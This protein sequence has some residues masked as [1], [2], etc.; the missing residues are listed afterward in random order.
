MQLTVSRARSKRTDVLNHWEL[1]VTLLGTEY[2]HERGVTPVHL[3]NSGSWKVLTKENKKQDNI[4]TTEN[5]VPL[6]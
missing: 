5:M 3:R 4:K 2:K 6:L 1:A